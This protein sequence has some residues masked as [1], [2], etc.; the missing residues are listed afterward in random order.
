MA[1]SRSGSSADLRSV[2]L[3]TQTDTQAR[4]LL[5]SHHQVSK[6]PEQSLPTS[7][8]IPRPVQ[9]EVR[10]RCGFGCVMCGM[11]LYEYEHLLG[12]ANVQRH[13]AD[14]ITLL[15]DQHH[16]EKTAGLLPLEAVREA[17]ANPFNLRAGVSKPYDLHFSGDTCEAVLGSNTFTFR[18]DGM[19]TFTVPVCIDGV[20]LLAFVLD[21]G[22]LLLQ[23]RLFDET[24]SPILQILNNQLIYS[25][26]PWDI[27]LVGRNLV[28]RDAPRKFLVDITFDVPNRIVIN[29]GRFLLNGVEILL[30]PDYFLVVN[31]ST[32][33]SQCHMENCRGGIIIGA[34][35]MDGGTAFRIA[36]VPRYLGDRSAAIR[37]AEESLGNG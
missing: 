9:R 12:W 13:V 3:I 35:D 19:P 1:R 33:M 30:T 17:N 26:S 31:N 29:R 15:C 34:Q 5:V 21:E 8:N 27:R 16:R 10:R 24:N 25:V 28:I 11:P 4:L 22:F 32:M 7:R 6:V 20:P 14:E 37:W 2:R 18:Y 23:L 36:G